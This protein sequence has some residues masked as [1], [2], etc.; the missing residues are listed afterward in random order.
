MEIEEV[1]GLSSN[2]NQD[3]EGSHQ[4]GISPLPQ[5]R[6]SSE[7]RVWGKFK[8]CQ[9]WVVTFFICFQGSLTSLIEGEDR[10]SNVSSGDETSPTLPTVRNHIV[11]QDLCVNCIAAASLVNN[12]EDA[13]LDKLDYEDEISISPREKQVLSPESVQLTQVV[14]VQGSNAK[15]G[16][17]KLNQ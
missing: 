16:N 15:D 13:L 6:T 2:D 3:S 10:S 17:L 9:N 8:L 11:R 5:I 1:V 12:P 14:P 4:R 7:R